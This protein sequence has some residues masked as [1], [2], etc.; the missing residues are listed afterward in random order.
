MGLTGRC[1]VQRFL[2]ILAVAVCI[3]ATERPAAS[4][5]VGINSA[6][7]QASY[8]NGDTGEVYTNY[9]NPD[10]VTGDLV[11]RTSTGA[12][13]SAQ[14]ASSEGAYAALAAL[15]HLHV[16]SFVSNGVVDSLTLGSSG[17]AST[18]GVDSS[19]TFFATGTGTYVDYKLTYHLDVTYG[20]FPTSWSGGSV[21][22]STLYIGGRNS[23]NLAV[24]PIP[25]DSIAHQSQELFFSVPVGSFFSLYNAMSAGSGISGT[26]VS[27]ACSGEFGFHSIDAQSYFLLKTLT[28]GGGFL[29]ESGLTYEVAPVPLPAAAMLFPTGLSL[30]ALAHRRRFSRIG[31]I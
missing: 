25:F 15:D 29:S 9:V 16:S 10:P 14:T 5:Y 19:D 23:A 20:G 21:A 12:N 26:C 1:F 22:N 13:G 6:T 11:G 31:H 27:G 17:A 8:A 3:V 18:L 7:V 4:Y 2:L 24:T 28:P 30:L